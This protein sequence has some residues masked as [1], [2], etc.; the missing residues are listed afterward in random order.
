MARTILLLACLT[1]LVASGSTAEAQR[2][3]PAF[4]SRPVLSPY[5]GL[6]QGNNAGLNSYFAA[7]RPMQM[8]ENF[9]SQTDLRVRTATAAHQPAIAHDAAGIAEHAARRRTVNATPHVGNSPCA[10]TAG[11]IVHELLEVLSAR[12]WDAGEH[13]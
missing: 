1:A 8:M 3:V 11:R 5:I 7:V 9:A 6:F 2:R 4:R 13:S 10:A 12:Q